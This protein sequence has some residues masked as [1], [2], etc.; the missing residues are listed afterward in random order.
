VGFPAALGYGIVPGALTGATGASR[1]VGATASGAPGS[2]TFALGDFVVAQNGHVWVCTV[3]GTP[4]TWI[5]AGAAGGAVASV[6]GRTGAVVAAANDYTFAQISTA[7][8]A[9]AVS[10]LA[11]GLA[12]QVIGGA[13][14]AYAYPPRYRYSDVTITAPVSITATSEATA[15]TVVTAGAVTFDGA[16][17]IM[18]EFYTAGATNGTNNLIIVLYDGASSIG[19]LYELLGLGAKTDGI[20]VTSDTFTP[21]AAAHTYSIRAYVDAGTGTIKADTGGVA[22]ERPA[23]IRVL[24]A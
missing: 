20:H 3:A 23:Y 24:Q 6:F 7:A 13:T 10:K 17:P 19:L 22:K 1:Y 2:G 18:I 15:N 9:I 21:S 16:T 5:D 4:G 14:P 11:A 8:N 12:G